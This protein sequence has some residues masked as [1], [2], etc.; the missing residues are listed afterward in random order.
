MAWPE[1]A[2]Q[3]GI[4]TLPGASGHGLHEFG[5][6]PNKRFRADKS[7]S[8]NPT[9]SSIAMKD[10]EVDEAKA[11]WRMSPIFMGRRVTR[12]RSAGGANRRTW[13]S[14]SPETTPSKPLRASRTRSTCYNSY[15]DY[16]IA[17][18]SDAKIGGKSTESRSR[19]GARS[20]T[21]TSSCRSTAFNRAGS[22]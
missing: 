1:P 18:I 12:V 17:S 5:A 14:P 21:R 9:G 19:N 16:L 13:R 4:P 15:D 11:I 7:Q 3:W 6:L 8:A 2:G 22:S 10:M 20:G